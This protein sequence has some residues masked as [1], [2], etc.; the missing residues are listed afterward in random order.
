VFWRSARADE[1]E[2]AIDIKTPGHLASKHP[3]PLLARTDEVI[4]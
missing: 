2:L 4:K 3:R 1:I